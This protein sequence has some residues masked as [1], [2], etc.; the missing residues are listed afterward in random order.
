MLK[1]SD[2]SLVSSVD[3]VEELSIR[4]D[5]FVLGFLKHEK[6]DNPSSHVQT[7]IIGKNP[8]DIYNIINFCN[9][10]FMSGLLSESTEDE[11]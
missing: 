8:Q 4:C 10:Q 11:L 6:V 3:L 7:F 2:L 9:H 1:Q 5:A